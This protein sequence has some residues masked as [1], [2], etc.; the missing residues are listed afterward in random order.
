MVAGDD[1]CEG[2]AGGKGRLLE[3]QISGMRSVISFEPMVGKE[4]RISVDCLPFGGGNRGLARA[5][6]AR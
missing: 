1:E 3:K 5:F 4:N 2:Q 6:P